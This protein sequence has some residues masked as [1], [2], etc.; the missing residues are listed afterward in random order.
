MAGRGHDE[1]DRPTLLGAQVRAWTGLVLG[2]VVDD[3]AVLVGGSNDLSTA[4]GRKSSQGHVLEAPPSGMLEASDGVGWQGPHLR[5]LIT[6]AIREEIL[7][8]EPVHEVA[9]LVIE[10]HHQGGVALAVVAVLCFFT[11]RD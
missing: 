4:A 8:V 9:L 3:R 1:N 5:P 10:H 7:E 6:V 2:G 11:E